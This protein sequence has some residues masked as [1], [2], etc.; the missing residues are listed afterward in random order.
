VSV[1]HQD[2]INASILLCTLQITDSMFPIGSFTQSYGLE[3]YIQEGI[4]NSAASLKDFLTTYLRHALGH[5]DCLVASLTY[6]YSLDNNF[7]L[8][9]ELDQL[10]NALKTSRET[11]EAS[12]KVGKMMLKSVT[13]LFNYPLIKEYAGAVKNNVAFG[14]HAVVF[15]LITQSIGLPLFQASTVFLYN[16]VTG[17]IQA[18]MKLIPLGQREGQDILLSLHPVI[19]ET[20]QKVLTLEKSDLGTLTPALEIR[21]MIHER[22]YTRL[23]MS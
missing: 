16:A 2:I 1:N 8:I 13:Q 3:T 12:L 14:H 20:A 19:I 23:F 10:V 4:I 21:C 5:K 15:G 7:D 6:K 18:G 17:M 9:I 22:L 11:R